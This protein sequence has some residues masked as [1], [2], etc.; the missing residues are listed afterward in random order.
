MDKSI[1]NECIIVSKQFGNDMVLAKNR[2]RAY[3]PEIEIV[4]TLING[5]EVVYLHDIT[6]DWSEGMNE[7]GIGIVNSS[8]LVGYDEKE[9]SIISKTG[10]KSQDGER[11]RHALGHK[12]IKEAL[13]EVVKYN[14]G[15][16]G[17]TFIADPK[18][19]VTIEMTSKHKPVIKQQDP[20]KLYVRTNHGLAHP[21]AG[22]T[23]G[24]DY[25]SSVIR[26][27]SA[28]SVMDKIKNWEDELL[29]LRTNKF[30]HENPNNMSRD[31]DKMKTT[32]QIQLNLTQKIFILNYWADRVENFKGIR[33]ELPSDYMPK[34]KIQIKDLAEKDWN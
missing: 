17:H 2:D 23:E 33:Q 12:T 16:K 26:R 34:I 30:S 5:V 15:V 21:D 14:G 19:L 28:K 20:S 10:K 11:I 25:K 9:K 27:A 8:L 13:P 31:T 18:H 22:Y 1:L 7:Y 3:K 24:P 6:T 32:S 4:H 29:G